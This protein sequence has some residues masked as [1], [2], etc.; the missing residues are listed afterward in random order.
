MADEIVPIIAG[1]ISGLFSGL[2]T[3]LFV[4]K[5]RAKLENLSRFHTHQFEVYN[6]LWK[7]LSDLKTSADKLWGKANLLNLK[8]FS[9][10]LEST[11][12]MVNQSALLI[13]EEHLARLQ[14]LIKTFW[15]FEFRKTRLIDLRRNQNEFYFFETDQIIHAVIRENAEVKNEYDQLITEINKSFKEQ[16]KSP[17]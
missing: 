5:Y 8:E 1:I 6:N 10:Q 4:E 16:L 13:E 7:S 2:V 14:E 17:Q 11:E 15:D 12:N 9:N 3:S